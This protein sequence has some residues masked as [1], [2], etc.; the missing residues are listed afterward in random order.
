LAVEIM[1]ESGLIHGR[2]KAAFTM[3]GARRD[4][5]ATPRPEVS[6]N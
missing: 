1:K 6:A 2:I 3:A 4:A 5:N